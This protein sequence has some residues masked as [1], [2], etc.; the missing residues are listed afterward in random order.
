MTVITKKTVFVH[1]GKTGGNWVTRNLTKAGLVEDISIQA[2]QRPAEIITNFPSSIEKKFWY[3]FVRHP[4]NWLASLWI[5]NLTYGVTDNLISP[6]ICNNFSGFLE[7]L[8]E[9]YSDGFCDF[10]LDEYISAC[11]FIGKMEN[12]SEDLVRAMFLGEETFDSNLARSRPINEASINELVLAAKAPMS[13]LKETMTTNQEFC[14]KFNYTSIPEKLFD[15]NASRIFPLPKTNILNHEISE[16]FQEII[17]HIFDYPLIPSD[18]A[19]DISQSANLRG[20][21][22][23]HLGLQS[24]SKRNETKLLYWSEMDG[25]GV[26]LAKKL[27]FKSIDATGMSERFSFKKLN[28]LSTYKINWKDI[29]SIIFANEKYDALFC[30][31]FI[32]NHTPELAFLMQ[33]SLLNHG[34]QLVFKAKIANVLETSPLMILANQK[35]NF[36]DYLNLYYPNFE[37][38]RCVGEAVGFCK[39]EIID[40]YDDTGSIKLRKEGKLNEFSNILNEDSNSLFSVV[41]IKAYYEPSADVIPSAGHLDFQD[42]W[43]KRRALWLSDPKN[44][45]EIEPL[46]RQMIF[47]KN[48]IKKSY[49]QLSIFK[50]AIADR[51]RD[52]EIERKELSILRRDI[53]LLVTEVE[54]LR[55]DKNKLKPG[56]TV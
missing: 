5:H 7:K 53:Q 50:A 21:W 23:L 2:H 52:L 56:T 6:L 13:I 24:F 28:N 8:N 10:Y 9:T 15:D 29:N 32:N 27:N 46:K 11:N 25:V 4:I 37:G 38:L 48:E 22:R 44:L 30:D 34:G 18:T 17:E 49:E 39:F 20:L 33:S 55:H 14:K 43:L 51:E 45:D 35:N 26:E 54:L 42:A 36:D 1:I 41:T 3:C 47:S 16:N 19:V 12:I 31:D 40:R